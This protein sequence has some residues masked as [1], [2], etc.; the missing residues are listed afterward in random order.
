MLRA[1]R[2]CC[3]LLP[4]RASRA[5]RSAQECKRLARGAAPRLRSRLAGPTG[6]PALSVLPSIHM[7]PM[8]TRRAH[9][10]AQIPCFWVASVRI[11]GQPS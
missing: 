6:A 5:V 8:H 11:I 3:G 7:V 2:S 9:G 1:V 10:R 4:V